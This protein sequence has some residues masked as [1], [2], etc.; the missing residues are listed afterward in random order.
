M[1]N[2]IFCEVLFKIMSALMFFFSIVVLIS[3]MMLIFYLVSKKPKIALKMLS[4]ILTLDTILL[5]IVMLLAGVGN[6]VLLGM[7]LLIPLL[8]VLNY[9]LLS[10][11]VITITNNLE[12]VFKIMP[13]IAAISYQSS[14]YLFVTRGSFLGRLGATTAGFTQLST[15]L[16]YFGLPIIGI[17]MANS[18][19]GSTSIKQEKRRI[20]LATFLPIVGSLY[21]LAKGKLRIEV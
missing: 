3:N 10:M 19:A 2:N 12:I 15:I 13:T 18:A 20:Y 11:V 14:L 5:L 17:A 1:L 9:V 16:M 7:F 6:A 21:V 8:I 4:S